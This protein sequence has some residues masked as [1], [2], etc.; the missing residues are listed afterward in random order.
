ML[1]GL[2]VGYVFWQRSVARLRE[3]VQMED[4]YV[5][6][7]VADAGHRFDAGQASGRPWG[8]RHALAA[9]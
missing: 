5:G 2:E 9:R 3:I 4:R 7:P 1:N 6:E 8:G